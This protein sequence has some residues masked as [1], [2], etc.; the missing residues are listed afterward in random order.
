MKFIRLFG[1]FSL[2][3]YYYVNVV[4]GRLRAVKSAS[5]RLADKRK[6]QTDEG[7][8]KRSIESD[9]E[10]DAETV[11]DLDPDPSPILTE[12]NFSLEELKTYIQHYLPPDSH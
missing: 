12:W 2:T 8:D 11:A 6:L 10:F 3:S 1:F 7:T 5:M 4:D 9:L